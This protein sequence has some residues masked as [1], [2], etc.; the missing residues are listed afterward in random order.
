LLVISTDLYKNSSWSYNT[1]IIFGNIF[2]WKDDFYEA[3]MP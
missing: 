1:K 2:L 3:E